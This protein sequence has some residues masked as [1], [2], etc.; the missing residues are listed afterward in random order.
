MAERGPWFRANADDRDV[1]LDTDAVIKI[2]RVA[3]G[4]YVPQALLDELPAL[5]R[6]Q[7]REVE[8][9]RRLDENGAWTVIGL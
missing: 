7:R 6:D 8:P 5:V 4:I 2:G 1:E 9:D 3:F